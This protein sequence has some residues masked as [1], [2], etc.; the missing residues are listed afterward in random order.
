MAWMPQHRRFLRRGVPA[1]PL[2]HMDPA[3]AHL[4]ST[5]HISKKFQL[6]AHLCSTEHIS[7]KFQL[8]KR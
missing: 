1:P 6:K 4:C 5:E 2:L 3:E 8:K 7:K